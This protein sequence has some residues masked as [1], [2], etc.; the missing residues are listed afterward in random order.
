VVF[1][2][3]WSLNTGSHKGRFHCMSDVAIKV[4][5]NYVSWPKVTRSPQPKVKLC[6]LI[7]ELSV[8]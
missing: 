1:E 4:D 7:W 5:H 3:R 6:P 8:A 2:Y